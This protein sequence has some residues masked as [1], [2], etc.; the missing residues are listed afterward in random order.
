MNISSTYFRLAH[1]PSNHLSLSTARNLSL[2][3]NILCCKSHISCLTNTK[4]SY[5]KLCMHH[6]IDYTQWGMR[7]LW[8]MRNLNQHRSTQTLEVHTTYTYSSPHLNN[9]PIHNNHRLTRNYRLCR[10]HNLESSC[11]TGGNLHSYLD[12]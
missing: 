5:R 1:T 2:K 9:T 8:I 3:D 7:W 6:Q 11:Y 10:K 4:R 12:Q